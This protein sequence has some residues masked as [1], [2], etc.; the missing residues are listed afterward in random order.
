[1]CGEFLEN[2]LIIS[3]PL[4]VTYI[5]AKVQCLLILIILLE[6]KFSLPFGSSEDLSD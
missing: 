3:D 1:M 6:V 5:K 2:A 4:T